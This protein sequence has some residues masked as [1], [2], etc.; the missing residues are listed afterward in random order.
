M[1]PPFSLKLLAVTARVT[2]CR[3]RH[4]LVWSYRLQYPPCRGGRRYKGTLGSVGVVTKTMVRDSL[5]RIIQRIQTG[6]QPSCMTLSQ[7]IPVFMER[8]GSRLTQGGTREAQVFRQF[9]EFTG[10]RVLD[11]ITLGTVEDYVT[12]RL[13]TVQPSTVNRELVVLKSV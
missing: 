7:F 9:L 6:P 5:L 4:G 2:V 11:Q 1:K 3:T 10:N 13:Q 8:H 12:T